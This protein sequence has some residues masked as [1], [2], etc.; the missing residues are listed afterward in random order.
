MANTISPTLPSAAPRAS[1]AAAIV[2]R[3]SPCKPRRFLRSRSCFSTRVA[4]AG[5]IA[6]NARKSPATTCPPLSA[7]SPAKAVIMPPKTN[8]TRYSY[9]LVSANPPR[10]TFTII[11]GSETP[12]TLRELRRTRAPVTRASLSQRTLASESTNDTPGDCRVPRRP[13]RKPS[14]GT[15]C[16]RKSCRVQEW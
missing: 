2:P 16:W 9:H 10:W 4:V 12:A 15:R 5:N 14:I 7:T 8:R 6:G 11:G 3:F 1:S 13:R